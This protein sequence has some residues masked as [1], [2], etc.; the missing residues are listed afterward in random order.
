MQSDEEHLQKNV[1]LQ[2]KAK[3]IRSFLFSS[4]L[5]YFISQMA[6][7]S[8]EYMA[9]MSTYASSVRD[10]HSS[11][12]FVARDFDGSQ[13]NTREHVNYRFAKLFSRLISVNRKTKAKENEM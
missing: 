1:S 2:R 12:F 8:I 3:T 11:R 5:K 13:A 7:R 10:K 6:N 9:R 4:A